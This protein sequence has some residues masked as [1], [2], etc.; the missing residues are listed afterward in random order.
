MS[1]S[2][3][4]SPATH[5]TRRQL[6]LAATAAFSAY[7]CTY[8]FRKPFTAGTFEGQEVF[9]WSLK[10]T[11]VIS[12]LL[13]YMLSKFIGI[14]VIS[15]MRSEGRALAIL[16]LIAIAEAALVG[17]A[18][19][20]VPLKVVMLFINGLPLGMI[21]GLIMAYLE[22]RRQTELLTAALCASFIVASGF[23]KSVGQWLM[24][25]WGLSEFQMP[26]V[27]GLLFLP[28]LLLAVW[29]LQSTPPPSQD[30]ERMRSRREAMD[31]VQRGQFLKAYW[32]G[33][34]LLVVVYVALT[35]TR[36]LRDDFAVEIWRDLGIDKTP[37]IFARTETVV[38]IVVT[39]LSGLAMLIPHNRQALRVTMSL[40]GVAFVL[41]AGAMLLQK[42]GRVSPFPFMVTCGI[43][44]YV[45]YVA[46]HTTVLERLI[47]AARRPCN[48]GFLMYLADS[49]GYL[50]YA[51]LIILKTANMTAEKVLPMFLQT[52]LILSMLSIVALAAALLYFERALPDE[53]PATAVEAIPPP[54]VELAPSQ[55]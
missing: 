12:Q 43:G 29:V 25:S 11:L 4:P 51:I 46:F 2:A 28:G 30:D 6:L 55:E 33:L 21:F 53:E 49:I 37:S 47:A 19:L 14:K 48:F 34:T 41:T 18:F 24:Q 17:F 1:E 38:G 50:G 22:G 13:G 42:S 10:I 54:R 40:M 52:S 9:G 26:M 8:A 27:A 5:A 7:F 20:P 31:R 3:I 39:A 15:E 23:V 16:G 45:P 35:M 36:T 32:P 44:L